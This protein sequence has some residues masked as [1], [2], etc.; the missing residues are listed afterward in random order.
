MLREARL[1]SKRLLR[2]PYVLQQMRTFWRGFAK[3]RYGF[4]WPARP[5]PKGLP[6]APNPLRAFFDAHKEGPGILKWIHSFDIYARHFSPFR[7]PEANVLSV[8][9]YIAATPYIL[10]D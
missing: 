7:N 4:D 3:W 6:E 9:I 8:L 2:T 10:N 5:E 1:R